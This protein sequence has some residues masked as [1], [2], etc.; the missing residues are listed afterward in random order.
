[1]LPRHRRLL[2]LLVG[3]AAAAAPARAP[4]PGR[5]TTRAAP[6]ARR[7]HADQLDEGTRELDRTL[8]LRAGDD[9][10]VTDRSW[11]VCFGWNV[12]SRR[13]EFILRGMKGWV[14]T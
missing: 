13:V 11:V 2:L 1:M 7:P 3:A 14:G 8:I 12:L 4:L 6:V 10:P 5:Q 9:F